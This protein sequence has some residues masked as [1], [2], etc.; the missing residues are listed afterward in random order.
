MSTIE[1]D[2]REV[3]NVKL[4]KCDPPIMIKDGSN[5]EDNAKVSSREIFD[6][7]VS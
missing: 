7:M 2:E 3:F 6:N 5:T 4:V 1:T